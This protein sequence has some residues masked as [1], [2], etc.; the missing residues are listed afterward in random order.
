MRS[1]RGG[2]E[3]SHEDVRELREQSEQIDAL[4]ATV[5]LLTNRL[6][7]ANRALNHSNYRVRAAQRQVSAARRSR[8]QPR[9][10]VTA[11][12]QPTA[13]VLDE[14]R[15]GLAAPLSIGSVDDVVVE[16]LDLGIRQVR[17]TSGI[18]V[19]VFEVHTLDTLSD[20]PSDVNTVDLSREGEV[21][22]LLE[23]VVQLKVRVVA[24]PELGVSDDET[25]AVFGHGVSSQVEATN[26]TGET[27]PAED[28]VAS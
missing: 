19:E 10:A 24:D 5:D 9:L 26:A 22:V 17:P 21:D 28:P 4:I 12:G 14:Q 13:G 20:P 7:G 1:L 16:I 27:G 11:D 8:E 25:S 18:W 3:R 6:A 2:Q 23:Q 15:I